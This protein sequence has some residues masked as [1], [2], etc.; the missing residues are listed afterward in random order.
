MRLLVP[1]QYP[2]TVDAYGVPL[3]K[4]GDPQVAIDFLVQHDAGVEKIRW[5]GYLTSKNEANVAKAREITAKALAVLGYAENTLNRLADGEGLDPN[6][7]SYVTVENNEYNGKVT[8]KI[9]WVNATQGSGGLKKDPSVIAKLAAMGGLSQE[10][11][12][13]RS[14][15]KLPPMPAPTGLAA[16]LM[17][18]FTSED[19]PF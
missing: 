6:R 7:V 4:D 14:E 8:N 5:Y 1:G 18:T 3:S 16:D 11:I 12:K 2:A 17:K 10:L 9:T 15:I 13:A 19:V